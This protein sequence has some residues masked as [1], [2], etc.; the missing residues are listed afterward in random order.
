MV[1]RSP[2]SSDPEFHSHHQPPSVNGLPQAGL[3]AAVPGTFT[4]NV[5]VFISVTLVAEDDLQAECLAVEAVRGLPSYH[6]EGMTIRVAA[7]ISP[8]VV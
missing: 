8:Q 2:D 4:V 1:S 6:R 7:V 5:P 3:P